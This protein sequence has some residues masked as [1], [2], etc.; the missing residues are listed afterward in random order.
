MRE[1]VCGLCVR[2]FY[3]CSESGRMRLGLCSWVPREGERAEDADKA[4]GREGEGLQGCR[5]AGLVAGDLW[6]VCQAKRREM[7]KRNRTTG[8]AGLGLI[9]AAAIEHE[10]GTETTGWNAR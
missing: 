1:R 5:A 2:E 10:Q 8:Q 3:R 7:S 6:Y 9:A 4:T